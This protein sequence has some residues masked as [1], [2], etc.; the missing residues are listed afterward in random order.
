MTQLLRTHLR[1]RRRPRVLRAPV[2][3]HGR[4]P[5]SSPLF[6]QQDASDFYWQ[7]M[8]IYLLLDLDSLLFDSLLL[9]C[10]LAFFTNWKPGYFAPWVASWLG[11]RRWPRR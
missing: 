1:Y 9:D 6:K 11:F 3:G 10:C 2:G 8:G 5:A 7:E 4:A